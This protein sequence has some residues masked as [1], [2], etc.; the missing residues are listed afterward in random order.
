VY[1]PTP[2]TGATFGDA[3]ITAAV[4]LSANLVK[5]AR[6]ANSSALFFGIRCGAVEDIGCG[7]RRGNSMVRIPGFYP[8]VAWLSDKGLNGTFTLLVLRQLGAVVERLW[9]MALPRLKRPEPVHG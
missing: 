9:R 8:A 1:Q 5:G 6:D 2:L 4:F 3:G 7:A